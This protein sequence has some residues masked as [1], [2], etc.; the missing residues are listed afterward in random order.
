VTALVETRIT[1]VM[2]HADGCPRTEF[3]HVFPQGTRKQCPAHRQTET[4]VPTWLATA[5]PGDQA[6]DA[7]VYKVKGLVDRLNL[8]KDNRRRMPE[9]TW[10]APSPAELA[11]DALWR[12]H[13]YGWAWTARELGL[14]RKLW[15]ADLRTA[16]KTA[17]IAAVEAFAEEVSKSV[18][19]NEDDPGCGVLLGPPG[20]GKTWA[21][22]A[23]LRP[24]FAEEIVW[25]HVADLV[26]AFH[27]PERQA[28]V[29][30]QARSVAVLVLDDFGSSYLKTGG[31]AA[32]LLEELVIAREAGDP[33]STT[34]IT[35]NFTTEKF[36]AAVGDR[37]F[38]RITGSWGRLHEVGGP[39]LR[40]RAAP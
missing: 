6:G 31:F 28:E 26:R 19:A 25:W 17:A 7:L 2:L 32:G 35:S 36:R 3:L 38:D 13:G 33:S 40:K 22:A 5:P 11:A 20:C 21:V 16:K 12:H 34:L 27:D 8:L 14:P 24:A 10:P 37:A 29:F 23:Y 15:A 18:D 1:A 9:Q 4:G 39:S 30:D